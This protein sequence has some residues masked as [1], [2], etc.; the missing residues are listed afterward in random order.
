MTNL[1]GSTPCVVGL[2]AQLLGVNRTTISRAIRDTLPLL[3]QYA[4]AI[5]EPAT[6]RIHTLADLHAY[7]A[8]KAAT[9]A[10]EI[11]PAC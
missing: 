3:N 9:L 5:P 1:H 7:A 4:S 8:A 10:Q 11:K 2:L 6:T